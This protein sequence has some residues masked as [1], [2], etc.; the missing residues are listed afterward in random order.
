MDTDGAKVWLVLSWYKYRTLVI[1][2]QKNRRT[3][4][5]MDNSWQRLE[6]IKDMPGQTIRVL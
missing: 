2:C 5:L 3:S 1:R 4:R 6:L